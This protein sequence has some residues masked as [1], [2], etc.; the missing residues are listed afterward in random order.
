MKA[1]RESK[2]ANLIFKNFFLSE[3]SVNSVVNPAE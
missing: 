3:S 1:R 2:D